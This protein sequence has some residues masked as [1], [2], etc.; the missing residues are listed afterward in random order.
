[1]KKALWLVLLAIALTLGTAVLLV[2]RSLRSLDEPLGVT[3]AV[4]FNVPAGASFAHVAADL[5]RRGIL[6]SP[7][8]WTWLARRDGT[9]IAIQAG[10]YRIGPGMT[11][12]ELLGKMVRGEV[13]FYSFTIVDGWRVRDLLEALR[14]E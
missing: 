6:A 14:H 2:A 9:A 1:M 3:A 4:N 11:P 7:R 5:H 13:V 12:R 10:E 8:A